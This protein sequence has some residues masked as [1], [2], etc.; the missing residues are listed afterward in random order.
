MFRPRVGRLNAS[1]MTY[2][3]YPFLP[4]PFSYPS[5]SDFVRTPD[6][7]FAMLGV[8]THP[9]VEDAGRAYILK[10]DSVGNEIWYKEYFPPEVWDTP[11]AYDLEVTSDGGFAFVGNYHPFDEINYKSWVVKTDA[12]GELQNLGCTEV[13]GVSESTTQAEAIFLSPNPCHNMLQ[14]ILPENAISMSLHD[15]T[16]RTV[17]QEKIYYPNQQW[18]VSALERG[19]YVMRVVCEDGM[20]LTTRL[21]K[22]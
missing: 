17:M 9:G 10:V 19:V 12:C 11:T 7:N 8:G 3:L 2:L 14:A 5:L 16:G 20:V 1:D 22:Q 13:V 6:G 4:H 18:N 21:L 15:A